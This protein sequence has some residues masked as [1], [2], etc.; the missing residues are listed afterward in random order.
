MRRTAERR[1]VAVIPSFAVDRT[2]VVLFH[3]RQL[4]RDGRVPPV[5]VYVDS[6][7]ALAALAVYRAAIAAGRDDVE[8]ALRG[9]PFDPGDLHEAQ[10]RCAI[11]RDQRRARIGKA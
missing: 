4:I 7:M 5:P 11:A 10:Y 6:P 8:P 1:G 9:D 2:E 3:I